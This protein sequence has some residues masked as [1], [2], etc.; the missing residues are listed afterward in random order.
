M[1]SRILLRYIFL[2]LAYQSFCVTAFAQQTSI[3]DCEK[4][5]DPKRRADC[6]E[7]I[8][9]NSQAEKK[10]ET[11][12]DVFA[13]SAQREVT[14]NLTDPESARFRSLVVTKNNTG[15]TL[16][17]EINAKNRVGGYVGYRRFLIS[18][19]DVS[20]AFASPAFER[21]DSP[22][23]ELEKIS[24]EFFEMRWKT[25]CID[26]ETVWKKTE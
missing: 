19:N 4:M 22:S 8:A 1:S 20:N 5:K 2:S 9:R 3:A 7:T 24:A 14:R 17:G 6:F 21:S 13:I 23:T 25:H 11:S 10:T 12:F 26:F 15:K 18:H 16:C